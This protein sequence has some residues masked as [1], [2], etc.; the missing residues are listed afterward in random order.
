MMMANG[1]LAI[2]VISASFSHYVSFDSG[3]PFFGF[4]I[5]IA[6]LWPQSSVK[7]PRKG[8]VTERGR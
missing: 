1:T 7:M 5:L 6:W 2:T 3:T 8:W 4:Q